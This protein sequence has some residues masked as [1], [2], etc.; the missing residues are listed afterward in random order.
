[1]APSLLQTKVH[2]HVTNID[3]NPHVRS[4]RCDDEKSL[5]VTLSDI[6]AAEYWYAG[7]ILAGSSDSFMCL[8]ENGHVGPLSRLLLR[9]DRISYEEPIPADDMLLPPVYVTREFTSNV[10]VPWTSLD[11]ERALGG[12]VVFTTRVALPED[13]FE[14]FELDYERKAGPREDELRSLFAANE[15]HHSE[16]KSVFARKL[17]RQLGFFDFASSAISSVSSAVSSATSYV[18]SAV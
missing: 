10:D 6:R 15:T 7:Q 3:S 11:S 18:S 1:M 12:Q 5:V 2:P 16:M 14:L 4:V 8:D 13:C 9:V 17:V